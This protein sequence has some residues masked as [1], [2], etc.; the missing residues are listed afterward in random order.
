MNLFLI[1]III[2]VIVYLFLIG[3]RGLVQKIATNDK[4]DSSL[5]IIN[6]RGSIF[7]IGGKIYIFITFSICNFKWT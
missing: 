5:F 3:K 7:T 4:K 2:F 1:G 6:S